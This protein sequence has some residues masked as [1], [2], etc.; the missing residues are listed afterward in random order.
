MPRTLIRSPVG[1]ISIRWRDGVLEGVDLDPTGSR[2]RGGPPS[3]DTVQAPAGSSPEVL[4]S[5][6]N[7]EAA[8]GAIVRQ[9]TDYFRDPSTTFDLPLALIGTRFQCKV[10]TLLRTIPAGTTR[11][12]GDLA[13]ELGS[14]ARAVGQAC[15][16]N[17]CPIVVPCHRV[18]AARGLG[19]FAGETSGPGLS[20]KRWLLEHEGVTLETAADR[21]VLHA[22]HG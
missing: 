13:R 8:P 14:A 2:P 21:F 18:V 12:Y 19:G 9:L 1:P 10:W 6:C 11:T 4:A 15:R 20:V 16:A 3:P 17:P 22:S 7:G 5:G